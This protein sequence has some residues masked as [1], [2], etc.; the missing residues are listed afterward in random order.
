MKNIPIQE[1]LEKKL[2][3]LE[4]FVLVKPPTQNAGGNTGYNTRPAD[5]RAAELAAHTNCRLNSCFLLK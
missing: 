2:K 4:N 3:K 1:K 5:I